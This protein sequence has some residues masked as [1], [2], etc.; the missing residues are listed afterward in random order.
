[1]SMK[2]SSML[3]FIDKYINEG[4]ELNRIL[5]V[6]FFITFLLQN[7]MITFSHKIANSKYK[8][9]LDFCWIS[10]YCNSNL[11]GI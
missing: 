1:M 6:N 11:I 8:K 5:R 4:R 2:F 3:S 7:F 9:L 10:I